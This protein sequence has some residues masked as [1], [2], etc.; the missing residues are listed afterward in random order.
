MLSSQR[1]GIDVR[2]V[3]SLAASYKK[4]FGHAMPHPTM[5][6]RVTTLTS[7]FDTGNKSLVFVRRIAS[8]W[9]LQQKL[10]ERYDKLLIERVENGLPEASR[11]AFAAQVARYRWERA[12][13][14]LQRPA[15]ALVPTAV[16]NVRDE[17]ADNMPPPEL[18]DEGGH[19]TFFAWFFRGKPKGSYLT[20]AR[21]QRRFREPGAVVSTMFEDNHASWLLGVPPYGCAE[22][23]L[24]S[25]EATVRRDCARAE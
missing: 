17:E 22:C 2:S 15:S 13:K 9:E 18:G 8:V 14:L 24:W 23:H 4:R 7:A 5:D 19:S 25:A 12:E 16:P 11:P 1:E 3:N 6:A 21:L 20:G 10:E